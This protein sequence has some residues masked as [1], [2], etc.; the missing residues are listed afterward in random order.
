MATRNF[1]GQPPHEQR[2]STDRFEVGCVSVLSLIQEST[3]AFNLVEYE[4]AR[5]FL[6]RALALSGESPDIRRRLAALH[7]RLALQR[8]EITTP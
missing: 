8:A 3:K 5:V 6:Q 1:V 2:E 7:L 4:N